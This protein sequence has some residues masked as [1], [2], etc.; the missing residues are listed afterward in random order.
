[1]VKVANTQAHGAKLLA[2]IENQ[3][4]PASDAPR[5]SDH[6]EIYSRWIEAMDAL[7]LEGDKL[8]SALVAHLN[9]YK[10]SIEYNLIFCS[11]E[12]FLYRQ[13]GQLKLDNTILEEFNTRERRYGK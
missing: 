8:L 12:Y 9:V 4:L 1:M 11:D 5:V 3:K 7:D 6:I 2:L 13:K 10:K